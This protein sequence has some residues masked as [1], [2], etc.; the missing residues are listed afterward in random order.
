MSKSLHEFSIHSKW[1]HGKRK[2]RENEANREK[3][4]DFNSVL[5]SVNLKTQVITGSSNAQSFLDKN[6]SYCKQV[7]FPQVFSQGDT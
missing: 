1:R 7:P 3:E 5:N 2:V 4:T 6:A